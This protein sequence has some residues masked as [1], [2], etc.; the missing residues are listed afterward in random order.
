MRRV[1]YAEWAF[2]IFH[3]STCIGLP[4]MVIF[5]RIHTNN[6]ILAAMACGFGPILFGRDPLW[7]VDHRRLSLLNLPEMAS[8][9]WL[10]PIG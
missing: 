3:G 8:C 2:F 9:G 6:F 5:T 1:R 10:M 7:A 4:Q